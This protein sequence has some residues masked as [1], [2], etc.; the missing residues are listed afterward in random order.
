MHGQQNINNAETDNF[1][2]AK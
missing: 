2:P 1:F